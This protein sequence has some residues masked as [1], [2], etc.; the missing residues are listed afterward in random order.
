MTWQ[1]VRQRYPN[2]WLL[3]EATRARSAEGKRII[4]AI[5]VLEVLP[6]ARAAWEAYSRLHKEAP[7]R[8]LFPISTEKE[9][10]EIKEMH[11]FERQ[12]IVRA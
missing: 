8:E 11:R 1:E 2:E 10:L 7:Q 4:E 3:I 9:N 6:D 12:S 5:A